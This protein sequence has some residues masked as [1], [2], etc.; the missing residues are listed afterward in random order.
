VTH[1]I[2]DVLW[3]AH[4]ECH[5]SNVAGKMIYMSGGLYPTIERLVLFEASINYI[6]VK[7]CFETA[8]SARNQNIPKERMTT[9]HSV[10]VVCKSA[11]GDRYLAA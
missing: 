4:N 7:T 10:K 5:F 6:S 2:I 8:Q 9:N 3:V 1:K 11:D